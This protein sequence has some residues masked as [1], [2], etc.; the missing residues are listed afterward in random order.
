[1]NA[2]VATIEELANLTFE[3]VECDDVK[4][5]L[6]EWLDRAKGDFP[7]MY[8]AVTICQISTAKLVQALNEAEDP[9]DLQQHMMA[10]SECITDLKSW[11]ENAAEVLNTAET[12]IL[13]ALSHVAVQQQAVNE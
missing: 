6:D 10:L 2:N 7:T 1:M 3:A 13:I 4:R 5:M 11:H 8:F 9:D 12:R